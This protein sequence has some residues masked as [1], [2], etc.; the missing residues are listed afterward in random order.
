MRGVVARRIEFQ[1]ECGGSGE[2]AF[3]RSDRR[4]DEIDATGVSQLAVPSG[5]DECRRVGGWRERAHLSF[6]QMWGGLYARQATAGINPAPQRPVHRK[7]PCPVRLQE[8]E[9]RP[10]ELDVGFV[11]CPSSVTR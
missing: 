1:I 10:R 5:G 7:Q 2:S 11:A 9:M 6:L 4:A 8:T 3:W